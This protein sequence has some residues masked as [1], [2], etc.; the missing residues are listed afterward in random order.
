MSSRHK[1]IIL[2]PDRVIDTIATLRN[3]IHERFGE[4]GLFRVCGQLLEIA[5]IDGQRASSLGRGYFGMRL[6]LAVVLA[7]GG[8]A[9][10][11]VA[12]VFLSAGP[13]RD[14]T[15]L[16]L[17]IESA[18]QLVLLTGA[19]ILFLVNLEER[20]K[21]RRA[22]DALH[23]LRSIVHVIDMHQLTKDPSKFIVGTN[24]PSSPPFELNEF[25]MTRYL[26]YCSEMLSLA[27]KVAVLFG[28]VLKDPAVAEAVSDIE[29]VSAGLSQKIWQKIMILQQMR[30]KQAEGKAG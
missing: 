19:A 17:G 14:I 24:T 28:Q 20:L 26:D 4:P 13:A 15:S 2:R 12:P 10:W 23:E 25:Q 21:R 3:R 29:H 27:S 6:L 5:R 22:L 16:L 9:L 1:K 18:V 11:Q 30:E 7:A 8:A